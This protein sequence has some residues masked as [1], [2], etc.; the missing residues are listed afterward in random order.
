V[1]VLW[2]DDGIVIRFPEADE[3]PPIESV[4]PEPEEVEDLVIRQL[5]SGAS[6]RHI[7]T[8]AVPVALF[9]SRFREAAARAL[10]LPRRHPGQR[11]ALWQ[12]RKRS[13]DLLHATSK[14]GSFP[15]ILETYRECLKDVFDMPALVEL[16]RE[17]RSRQIRVLPVTSRIPSPF[18]AS[19][20]FNYVSNFM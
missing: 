8:S 19:L 10:L 12:Q 11:A 16:L 17:I 1:D 3:P 5:G 6:A 20:M 2:T 13:S 14:Y 18:A 15:I 9:A 7:G 4:I